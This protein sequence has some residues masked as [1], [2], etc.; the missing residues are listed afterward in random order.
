MMDS[1]ERYETI[2]ENIHDG[3]YT[4]D[5]N[6]RITWV[7]QTAVEEFDIGYGSDE[8]IG[9]YVSKVLSDEDIEKCLA[10]IRNCLRHDDR[11]SGRCEI[12]LQTA[13]GSEIPCDLHLALL[14]FEN[15]E[16]QGTVGVVRD[17]SDRKRREQ[18]L[19]VL[20]RLLRH[21]LRNEVNVILGHAERL[22]TAIDDAES[23]QAVQTIRETG[24]ELIEL[25][26]KSRRLAQLQTDAAGEDDLI[27]AVAQ[28]DRLLAEF[29][30]EY[31]GV[32]LEFETPSDEGRPV[33]A[34]QERW[35]TTA[36]RNL[37]ENAIEH[38]TASQP[39]VTVTVQSGPDHTHVHVR[40][41][42]P[43]L[44]AVEREVLATGSETPLQHGSGLG[45]W[46][47]HWCVTAFG[48]DISFDDADPHGTI[49]TLAF[50]SVDASV[51][52]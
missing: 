2:L 7:N 52:Q 17:I 15:G 20:N 50:P 4:L 24:N 46:L 43:G 36:V 35:F 23:R 8:L 37:I 42:G 11:D 32:A 5:A 39:R 21:N 28:I 26:N 40:D 1:V 31:P 51:S 3:V 9:A 38:N 45:L 44:P 10:I 18:R 33:I 6:G 13:Y 22:Q 19:A 16:F 12:A 29:R 49:V 47:V 14:P 30:D 41:N 27:D 34:G 25:S 48:G